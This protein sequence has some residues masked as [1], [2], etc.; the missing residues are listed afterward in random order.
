MPQTVTHARQAVG[1]IVFIEEVDIL[2]Q[3]KEAVSARP[4]ENLSDNM[5]IEIL[6]RAER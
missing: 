2:A 4:D 1:P 6:H 3:M 5:P